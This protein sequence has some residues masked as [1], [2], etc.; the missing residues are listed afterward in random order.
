M[1]ENSGYIIIYAYRLNENEE[2]VLGKSKSANMFVTWLCRN[3]TDY[4][5][6][7]YTEDEITALEDMV[8]RIK[9]EVRKD[10]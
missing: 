8:N 4:Y 1:R 7:H 5:W 9:A 10:G 2:I 6:G 3:Q